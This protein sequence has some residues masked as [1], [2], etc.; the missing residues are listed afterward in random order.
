M[1]DRLLFAR[2][3]VI[4]DSRS[5][6]VAGYVHCINELYEAVAPSDTGP[7]NRCQFHLDKSETTLSRW[8]ELSLSTNTPLK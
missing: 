2:I 1:L 5:E 8:S 6:M 3:N 7:H 4:L